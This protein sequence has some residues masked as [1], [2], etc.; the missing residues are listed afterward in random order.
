ME[1]VAQ[2]GNGL[3]KG[4]LFDQNLQRQKRQDKR[5]EARDARDAEA[6]AQRAE[7]TGLTIQ[8]SK[9]E[10]GEFEA[11]AEVRKQKR[12][13]EE[14]ALQDQQ[15]QRQ[16]EQSLLTAN[17]SFET[18]GK[19][20]GFVQHYNTLVNDGQ[21]AT[22]MTLD[23]KTG[24]VDVQLADE[25]GH[26]WTRSFDNLGAMTA[27]LNE[28][29]SPEAVRAAMEA[30][31]A[32]RRRLAE[33]QRGEEKDDRRAARDHGYAVDL[34]GRRS[35]SA[36]AL[37]KLRE[38][39]DAAGRTGK[40]VSQA[41]RGKLI[42]ETA[43]NLADDPEYGSMSHSERVEAAKQLVDSL[44]PDAGAAA[45]AAPAAGPAAG[46]GER[47]G[48]QPPKPAAKPAAKPA[49]NKPTTF[50]TSTG[51]T[52]TQEQYRKVLEAAW[53]ANPAADKTAVENAVR[54]RYGFPSL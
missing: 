30:K 5:D 26:T 4:Y 31:E 45:P 21:S 3:L 33:E 27:R 23:P 2:F 34:Q 16:Y 32:E 36:E 11:G 8:R 20:D 19:L 53:S 6:A 46:L 25:S 48:A 54:Q 40:M 42:L 10:L 18:T 39:A 15:S 47:P 52:M 35:A 17:K 43:G 28:L 37:L 24:R 13:A 44:Y 51:A 9:Q 50:K 38:E 49:G 14:Q 41:D 7:A 22:G 12:A 1:N 29:R